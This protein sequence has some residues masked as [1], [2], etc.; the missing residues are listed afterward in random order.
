MVVQQVKLV[1]YQDTPAMVMSIM[2]EVN[3]PLTQFQSLDF[4]YDNIIRPIEAP[5][6]LLEQTGCHSLSE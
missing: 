4:L 3:I 1:E 2:C 6:S 5:I